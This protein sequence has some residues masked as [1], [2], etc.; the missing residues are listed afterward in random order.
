MGGSAQACVPGFKAASVSCGLKKDG[1]EDLAIFVSRLPTVSSVVFTKNRV[2]AAPIIWTE[3]HASMRDLHGVLVNSGN[4]NACTGDAG[5]AAVGEIAREVSRRLSLPEGKI[6]ISSTGV[7]GVPLPRGRIIGKLGNLCAALSSSGFSGAAKAMMT[8]DRYEKVCRETFSAGGK[9]ITICGV[10]KGAG[11]ISPG[12]GTMLAYLFT[13]CRLPQRKLDSIFRRGVD[14]TFNRIIVDGDMSTNDTAAVF[15]NGATLARPLK[16]VELDRFERKMATVMSELALKIVADGEGA[17]RTV[18]IDVRGAGSRGNAEKVARAVGTS[19]LVKTAIFGAD[20]NWGRIV[21]A[22]GRAG[23]QFDPRGIVV[24]IGEVR[25][26]G[27]GMERVSGGIRKAREKV[28]RD[29]YDI[30]LDL[31][32]GKG[33]YFVITSDLTYDYVRLNSEYTT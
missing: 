22:A 13:D 18:K 5:V 28:K 25:V 15:A 16:G 33:D 12:M 14:K 27:P 2:R 21:A 31:G 4:A 30:T 11:M 10:A 1:G 3:T 7:I 20:L 26:F 8:T 9:T 23:V 19:L 17:T 32:G 6:L 29:S 24:Y